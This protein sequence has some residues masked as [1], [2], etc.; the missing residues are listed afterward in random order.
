M[1]KHAKL[2]DK[3]GGPAAVLKALGLKQSRQSVSNWR[4]RGVPWRYRVAVAKLAAEKNIS[5]PRGF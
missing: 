2:I 4:N 3:L 1:I 5:V